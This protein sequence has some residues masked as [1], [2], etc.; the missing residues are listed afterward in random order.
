MKAIQLSIG[1]ALCFFSVSSIAAPKINILT[2]LNNDKFTQVRITNGTLKE[3]ACYVAIDGFKRKFTLLP[4]DSSEW[5]TATDV[6]YKYS[7]FRTWCD[8][9]E[10]YP[11]YQ[12]YKRY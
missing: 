5:Y 9:I 2:R 12:K 3:L 11:E 1:I 7:D 10:F 6:R 8:F 4:K